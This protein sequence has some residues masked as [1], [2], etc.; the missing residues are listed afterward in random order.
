MRVV[1]SLTAVLNSSPE[2]GSLSDEPVDS[3]LEDGSLSDEP[4]ASIGHC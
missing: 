1:G 4:G 3:S 2:D